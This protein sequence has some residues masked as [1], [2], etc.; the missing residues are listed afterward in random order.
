MRD[1]DGAYEAVSVSVQTY[2]YNAAKLPAVGAPQSALDFLKPEI[3]RQRY[4][5]LPRPTMMRH[6][7]CFI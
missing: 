6:F 5:L 3:R 2:A 7:I 4:N 1:A